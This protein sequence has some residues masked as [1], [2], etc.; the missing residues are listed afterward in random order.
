MREVNTSR[1]VYD[2][3]L[4]WLSNG[5]SPYLDCEVVTW[6]Y[7]YRNDQ[8]PQIRSRHFTICKFYLKTV[9]YQVRTIYMVR[10][11]L[12]KEAAPIWTIDLG[13]HTEDNNSASWWRR[14]QYVGHRG[15]RG[16]LLSVIF[17]LGSWTMWGVLEMHWVRDQGREMCQE[18]LQSGL[19]SKIEG[20]ANYWTKGIRSSAEL[21]GNWGVGW[22]MTLSTEEELAW[23]R[24]KQGLQWGRRTGFMAMNVAGLHGGAQWTWLF[25]V[26]LLTLP[27]LTNWEGTINCT[28]LPLIEVVLSVGVRQMGIK[29]PALLYC[30]WN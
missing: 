3:K 28:F 10:Y 15:A 9:L 22:V 23:G 1:N 13:G 20:C 8:I 14:A 16:V 6:V 19:A 25:H 24:K 17:T 5:N 21:L 27:L 18:W 11:Y 26:A 29:M 30:T 2:T 4:T 7:F 12:Y